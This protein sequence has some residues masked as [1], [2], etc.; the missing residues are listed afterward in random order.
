MLFRS[1]ISKVPLVYPNQD[2]ATRQ[3]VTLQKQEESKNR[4]EKVVGNVDSIC[5]RILESTIMDC[6]DKMIWVRIGRWDGCA[7]TW[8]PTTNNFL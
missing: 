1:G 7:G 4:W 3:W 6:T 8:E 5:G 2:V